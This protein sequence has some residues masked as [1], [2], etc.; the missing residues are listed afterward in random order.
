MSRLPISRLPVSLLA[1]SAFR[2]ARL[3]IPGLAEPRAPGRA[4]LVAVQPLGIRAREQQHVAD[5]PRVIPEDSGDRPV[6]RVGH[7]P[8]EQHDQPGD[9][10][11]DSAHAQAEQGA[12]QVGR[13]NQDEPEEDR[14]AVQPPGPH[15]DVHRIV[16]IA[17][18]ER[19][20]LVSQQEQVGVDPGGPPQVPSDEACEALRHTAGEQRGE[21]GDHHH[22][23][24]G[25]PEHPQHDVVRDCQHEAHQHREPTLLGGPRER[26]E[27]LVP[28]WYSRGCHRGFH[29]QV[30]HLYHSLV[31]AQP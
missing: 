9:E 21:P 26:D 20:V 17:H 6:E 16:G 19:R 4:R 31:E 27:N 28:T 24:R 10:E 5:V 3:V 13:D 12:Q 7:C 30:C 1:V 11:R 18:L 8:G 22:D 15:R 23:L 25:D 29:R 2:G 14:E